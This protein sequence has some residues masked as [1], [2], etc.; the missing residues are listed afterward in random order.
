ML[1]QHLARNVERE[2]VRVDKA[3]QE[4]EVARQELLECI[5]DEDAAHVQAHRGLALVVVI[6]KVI[7]RLVWDVQDRTELDVA[8]G[9][10]V[11]VRHR[12]GTLLL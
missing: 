6:V 11:G 8:L 5:R 9:V 7:R 3:Q 2:R 1:L 4:G 12:G 10:E